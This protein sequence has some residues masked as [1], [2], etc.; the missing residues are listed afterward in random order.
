MGS[1]PGFLL[2][3]FGFGFLI[4]IHELGHFLAAKWAGI[5]AD[6]FAIGMGPCVASYRRGIGF[7]LGSADARVLRAQ[8]RRPI[9]M[10]DSEL[11]LRGLGET[12]YSFRVLPIGGY[13][14]MLGQED[15]NPAATSTDARSF[16]RA[17]I[18]RR[19]VVILAGIA[20][21]IALAIVL[22]LVAFLVGVRFPAPTVGFVAPGS[23]AAKAEPIPA[24]GETVERGLQPG[25][26]VRSI[27]DD[28]VGTFVDLRV[29]AAMA[30]PDATLLVEVERDGTT[31]LFKVKPERDPNLGLLS[32]GVDPARSIEVTS[33]RASRDAVERVLA[34]VPARDP[35]RPDER[36]TLASLGMQP[37]ARLVRAGGVETRT[38][39]EIASSVTADGAPVP[40]TWANPD[41]TR[42]DAL[43][44]PEPLFERLPG[45]NSTGLAGLAPLPRVQLVVEESPNREVLRAG[46]VFL[47]VEGDP[48]L[49]VAEL[50]K[51]FR[52]KPNAEIPARILRDGAPVEVA[53][54]TD[55]EGRVGVYLAS[56][57]DLPLLA[58]PVERTGEGDGSRDT[59]AAQLEIVPLGSIQSID[60]APVADFI[61]ARA[62]LVAIARETPAGEP[63]EIRVGLLDPSPN[64]APV[65]ATCTLAAAD[66][67]SLRGLGH[68]FPIPETIFDP[69]YTVLSAD[70]NPLRA[71]AMGF[72]QTVITMEQVFLTIDRLF[73]RSVGVEQLQGPIGILHTGTQVADEGGMFL[74]F[75]LALI[76][77]NLAV[78]NALPIPIADGGLFLFLMYEKVTG[79]P[80]SIAFQNAAATAGILLVAGLFLLTFYNDIGRIFG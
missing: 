31:T 50:M 53:L 54:R 40:I 18:P 29:A 6:G 48:G 30:R 60:G 28:A 45:E 42:G 63:R 12:E 39:A 69:E 14:R 57:F 24:P 74:L 47:S 32:I 11:A 13:V 62:R 75:F 7:C 5:R 71:I 20:A 36:G 59:P 65:E 72:R 73:R 79:R 22:F 41:G 4:F 35:A 58:R 51:R 25:D 10:T 19:A 9:E 38:F 37:G 77:V 27:D 49:R 1:L 67:E 70:G 76:S 43:V 26:I 44:D 80:P 17:T 56:A 15:G 16:G 78:V 33:V 52:A 34:E 23:P 21:N 66:L 55:G 3:L 8:G 2:V 64:A 46:D 61:A 68:A